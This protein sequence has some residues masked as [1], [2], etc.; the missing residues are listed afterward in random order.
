MYACGNEVLAYILVSFCLKMKCFIFVLMVSSH[1]RC[2]AISTYSATLTRWHWQTREKQPQPWCSQCIRLSLYVT[3]VLTMLELGT[4]GVGNTS[5]SDSG[6]SS[7]APSDILKGVF[8][9]QKSQIIFLHFFFILLWH[10]FCNTN[11]IS[12]ITIFIHGVIYLLG[13]GHDENWL[14]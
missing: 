4:L 9:F 3:A 6:L 1:W 13:I 14:L 2:T 7:P 5:S 10:V 12:I 8:L 11:N